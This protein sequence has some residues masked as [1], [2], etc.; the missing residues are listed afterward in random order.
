MILQNCQDDNILKV[1][2]VFVPVE[3]D[4]CMASTSSSQDSQKTETFGIA[5]I[6]QKVTT[7]LTMFSECYELYIVAN[8]PLCKHEVEDLEYKCHAF[9]NW[10][11][12]S[13]P[14]ENLIRKFHVLTFHIPEKARRVWTFGMEAEQGIE[15]VHPFL[16]KWNMIYA[17]VQNPTDRLNTCYEGSMATQS[18]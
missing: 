3:I 7:L 11:P 17:T 4:I 12:T 10:F 14:N 6:V 2:N 8:R 1:A 9:G 13:F 5:D 15:G 18:T 16:N